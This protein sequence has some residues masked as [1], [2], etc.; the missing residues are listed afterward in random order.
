MTTHMY[1][2]IYC[3]TE[4]W[5]DAVINKLKMSSRLAKLE[6]DVL[7]S[8]LRLEIEQTSSELFG[9]QQK[10]IHENEEIK[11]DDEKKRKKYK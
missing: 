5:T 2:L 6:K 7:F 11:I 1:D 9:N 8:Q 4:R 3:G 10:Y